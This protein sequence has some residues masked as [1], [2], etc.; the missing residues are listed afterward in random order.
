MQGFEV[1]SI[2]ADSQSLMR[3][4]HGIQRFDIC[5][6]HQNV[7]AAGVK[8]RFVAAIAIAK[9]VKA[10]ERS[11]RELCQD[12]VRVVSANDADAFARGSIG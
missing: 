4:N 12:R 11:L 7:V 8:A 5:L 1:G 10:L 3:G 9:F 2:N 6:A